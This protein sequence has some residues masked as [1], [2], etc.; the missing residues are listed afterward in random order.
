MTGG[1]GGTKYCQ[2]NGGA[3]D[4]GKP[5]LGHVW[6]RAQGMKGRGFLYPDRKG[7]VSKPGKQAQ[8]ASDRGTEEGL[9]GGKGN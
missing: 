8:D 6:S 1:G 9:Q 7:G 2:I 4:P 3:E 5:S